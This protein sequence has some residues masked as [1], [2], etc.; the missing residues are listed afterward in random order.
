[1]TDPT[2]DPAAEGRIA[3][4]AHALWEEEGRPH[5]RDKEHWAQAEREVLDVADELPE[6]QIPGEPPEPEPMEL[7]MTGRRRKVAR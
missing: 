4:R 7:P 5:D 6:R 3:S 1:M 2:R